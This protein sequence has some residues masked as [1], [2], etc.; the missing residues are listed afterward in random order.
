MPIGYQALTR[1]VL[2]SLNLPDNCW[3]SSNTVHVINICPESTAQRQDCS[4]YTYGADQCKGIRA[5][6]LKIDQLGHIFC[7]FDGQKD[8]Q[9]KGQGSPE[10]SL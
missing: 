2:P 1:A 6:L 4:G 3:F 7:C 5:I 8:P 9:K 10:T